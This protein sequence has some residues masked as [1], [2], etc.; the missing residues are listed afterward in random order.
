MLLGPVKFPFTPREVLKKFLK[1]TKA[2]G[3]LPLPEK[4]KFFKGEEPL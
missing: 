4:K 2:D 3:K 1:Q